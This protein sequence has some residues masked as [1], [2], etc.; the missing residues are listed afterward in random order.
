MGKVIS[1]EINVLVFS[2]SAPLSVVIWSYTSNCAG[3]FRFS[4][5]ALATN[6]S[7]AVTPSQTFPVLSANNNPHTY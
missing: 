3:Y 5:D 4:T 6:T 7:F 2:I 1:T